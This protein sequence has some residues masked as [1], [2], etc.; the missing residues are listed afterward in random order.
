MK[1]GDRLAISQRMASVV[2]H[3]KVLGEQ[4]NA[5]GARH[6]LESHED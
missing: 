5:I 2:A 6:T 1:H 3:A 4:S